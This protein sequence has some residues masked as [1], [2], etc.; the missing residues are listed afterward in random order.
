[1]HCDDTKTWGNKARLT[2]FSLNIIYRESDFE[3]FYS[4]GSDKK[5]IGMLETDT[6]VFG[7]KDHWEYEQK[8]KPCSSSQAEHSYYRMAGTRV[9][10]RT[11]GNFDSAHPDGSDI[12]AFFTT[13]NRFAMLDKRI[14]Q[15]EYGSQATLPHFWLG[16]VRRPDPGKYRFRLIMFTDSEGD[17]IEYTT[18]ELEF[19]R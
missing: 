16:L 5:P 8:G 14:Y 18:P 13:D 12:S 3:E 1:M 4:F 2:G 9:R 10:I 15:E 6:I 17:G 7:F 19:I 11:I